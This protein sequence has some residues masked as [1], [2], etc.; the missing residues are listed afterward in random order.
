MLSNLSNGI[1]FIRFFRDA[2]GR[3]AARPICSGGA[4]HRPYRRIASDRKAARR[5]AVAPPLVPNP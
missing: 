5:D 4:V 3:Q 2:H 1:K